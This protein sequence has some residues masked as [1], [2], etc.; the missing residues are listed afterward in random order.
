MAVRKLIVWTVID[1]PLDV[2]GNA[3]TDA[4]ALAKDVPPPLWWRAEDP[5]ALTT[6]WRAG[7]L[8]RFEVVGG[9][10]PV[11]RAWTTE[12][13][14]GVP[15]MRVTTRGS[16]AGVGSWVH[17]RHLER[18]IGGRV[19]MVDEVVFVAP[20]GVVDVLT[21]LAR[22]GLVGVHRAI[23]ARTGGQG[24][25]I[26]CHRVYRLSQANAEHAQDALAGGP[27]VVA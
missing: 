22:R 21:A 11:S 18:A 25:E 5:D 1:A 23:T 6:A 26:G 4:R 7:S 20:R 19:R 2:L 8:G 3:M 24:K 10:G 14:D 15:G 17:R 13:T 12:I 27:D 9:A 16:L